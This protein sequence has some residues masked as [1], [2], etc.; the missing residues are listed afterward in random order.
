MYIKEGIVLTCE[1]GHR[2]DQ[3]QG[4][5]KITSDN[6]FK[7]EGKDCKC[8]KYKANY[9]TR[10]ARLIK[11]ELPAVLYA[12]I[13]V[14]SCLIIG[15][16]GNTLASATAYSITSQYDIKPHYILVQ[17]FTNGTITNSDLNED[18]A[19]KDKIT[20]AVNI[21]LDLMLF[22]VGYGGGMSVW[23]GVANM[24]YRIMITEQEIEK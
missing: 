7:C 5:K 13:I 19:I 1:C 24:K 12:S 20:H 21:P 6:R 8:D 18:I 15:V 14:I 9:D 16:L 11:C 10:H 2:R 3:H 4:S 23:I 22:L 17:K